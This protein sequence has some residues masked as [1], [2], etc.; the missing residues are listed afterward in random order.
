MRAFVYSAQPSRVVF[1]VG[2]LD[3]LGAEIERLGAKRAL[4]LSTPEQRSSAEEVAKRLG[5]RAAGVYDRAV[6][7]VP[8]ET[9]EAAIR[10]LG[11]EPIPKPLRGGTDGA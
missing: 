10:K 6:M 7:Y 11:L 4:V 1:G 9:A 5:P 2:A 3:Q 8:L